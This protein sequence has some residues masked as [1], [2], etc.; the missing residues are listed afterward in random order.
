M[1]PDLPSDSMSQ[2]SR[3]YC[4]ICGTQNDCPHHPK[5]NPNFE[6]W[7]SENNYREFSSVF[8]YVGGV[9]TTTQNFLSAG[10]SSQDT[11]TTI[12]PQNYQAEH[13]IVVPRPIRGVDIQRR[14][15]NSIANQQPTFESF[16]NTPHNSPAQ[17]GSFVPSPFGFRS[18]DWAPQ[19]RASQN[20]AAAIPTLP[21]NGGQ[22]TRKR[23]ADGPLSAPE[24]EKDPGH[25]PK[26]YKRN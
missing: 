4:H 1:H 26:R 19:S 16:Y 2:N 5:N 10:A 20:A 14:T 6:H 7:G 13:Q 18:D 24:G 22:S 8:R 9:T 11:A 25:A 23:A 15:V 17:N 12:K 21:Q 3:F